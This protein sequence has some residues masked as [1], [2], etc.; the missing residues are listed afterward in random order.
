MEL[1]SVTMSELL[2]LK[3]QNRDEISVL[4]TCW[5]K[6]WEFLQFDFFSHW[7]QFLS[8]LIGPFHRDGLGQT[9]EKL[10]LNRRFPAL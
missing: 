9:S 5:S 10:T 4:E 1:V 7:D 8:D 2:I 6:D 3:V